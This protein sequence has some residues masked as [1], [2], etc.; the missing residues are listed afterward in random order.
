MKTVDEF[1]KAMTNIKAVVNMIDIKGAEN[2][3]RVL[4]IS[5]ACDEVLQSLTTILE[6]GKEEPIEV[7][8]VPPKDQNGGGK[9]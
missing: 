1:G 5:Q 7:Q 2:A 3:A 8:L 6:D 9:A 4:F